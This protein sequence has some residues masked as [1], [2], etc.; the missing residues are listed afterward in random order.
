M[1]RHAAV[2]LA[3]AASLSLTVV[4]GTYI[5]NQMA[6]ATRS[7]G[8]HAAPAAPTVED[9]TS[10]PEW[11]D[12][13]LTGGSYELPVTF[14]RHQPDLPVPSPKA[15]DPHSGSTVV[16]Q[17]SSPLG[18]KWRLGDTYI[19][20]QVATVRSDT[21]AITVD[22][23]AFTVLTGVPQSDPAK[24][25]SEGNPSITQLRTEFDTRSGEVVLML[26]DPSLGEYDLRLN[27]PQAS[28]T[29]SAPDTSASSNATSTIPGS[30]TVPESGS[31]PTKAI[32]PSAPRGTEPSVAV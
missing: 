31:A 23:N 20:A 25:R 32:K 4:A 29:K 24:G 13:V 22:T 27:Q 12:A 1:A 2:V 5:V 6:D 3:G 7:G 19:G 14:A 8:E 21:I 17:P 9:A 10:D 30:T 15:A 16:R 28:E 11:M 26:T 18:G